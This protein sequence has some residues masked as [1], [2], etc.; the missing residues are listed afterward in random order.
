MLRRQ[1]RLKQRETTHQKNSLKVFLPC[2]SLVYNI[3]TNH[4]NRTLFL[5]VVSSSAVGNAVKRN[6]LKRRVRHI[7]KKLEYLWK[8]GGTYSFYFKKGAEKKLFKELEKDIIFLFN[9]V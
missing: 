7:I 4:K 8:D 3:S 2:I 1:N 9:K 6:L 5:I